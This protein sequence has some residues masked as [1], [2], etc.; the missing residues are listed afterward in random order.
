MRIDESYYETSLEEVELNSM[1]EAQ[2]RIR[3]TEEQ[4]KHRRVTVKWE[5]I[6][7]LS[8]IILASVNLC[9]LI[10]R[11]AS[12][13]GTPSEDTHPFYTSIYVEQGE[14]LWTIASRYSGESPLDITEYVDELKHINRLGEN[15]SIHPGDD[16]TIVY[17]K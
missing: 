3:K 4:R 6:L 10:L 7:I 9:G 17:Y 5:K 12:A 1:I 8:A 14:S 15:E 13:S 2:T 11:K 16:L